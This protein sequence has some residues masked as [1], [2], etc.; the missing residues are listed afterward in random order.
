M[1]DL[2]K[3]RTYRAIKLPVAERTINTENSI[4]LVLSNPCLDML[5]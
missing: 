4:L 2:P 3:V 5:K 1:P